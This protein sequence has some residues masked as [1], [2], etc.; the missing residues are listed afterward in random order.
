MTEADHIQL[1]WSGEWLLWQALTAGLSLVVLVWWIYRREIR[2]GTS[3]HLRW[4]LPG[5]RSLA[6]LGLA[7]TLAG[8]VLRLQKEEGNRGRITV[9]LD[10]SQSMDLTDKALGPGRKILL[11][12]EHGFLPEG[13]NLVD[14]RIHQASRELKV[15]AQLLREQ[16]SSGLTNQNPKQIREIIFSVI[17]SLEGTVSKIK[18]TTKENFLLEEVWFNLHGDHW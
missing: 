6:L 7:L 5:L 3:G 2:K 15:L 11:A 12:R 10:S 1:L 18:E 16:E 17:K 13:S 9:F 4:V 8:P 14:F